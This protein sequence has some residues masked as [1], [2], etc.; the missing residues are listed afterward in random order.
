MR[1]CVTVTGR[2]ARVFT[3]GDGDRHVDLRLDPAYAG[4]ANMFNRRDVDGLLVTETVPADQ[5]SVAT[6]PLGARVKVTGP[7]VIDLAHG[8][9]EVHPVWR[10]EV[11]R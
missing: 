5:A 2:A 3:T 11:L 7:L 10:V 1:R 8:W 9:V 6:P 4:L